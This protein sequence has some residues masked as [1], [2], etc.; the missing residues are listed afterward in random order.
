MERPGSGYSVGTG[1]ATTGGA[2]SGCTINIQSVGSTTYS[3]LNG[4]QFTAYS[5]SGTYAT[6]TLPATIRGVLI[7]DIDL[8]SSAQV[9][10]PTSQVGL[11]VAV[12]TQGSSSNIAINVGGGASALTGVT[13][14]AVQIGSQTAASGTNSGI[15]VLGSTGTGATN[16]GIVV[17]AAAGTN[18]TNRG[19]EIV[20][21][22]GSGSSVNI[23][24]MI[25]Q[26]SGGTGLQQA[27][28]LNTLATTASA[29]ILF[30]D[31]S[32]SPSANL[33]R[34]AASQV[35]CDGDIRARHFLGLGSTPSI[36]AG[37]GA[38]TGPSVTLVGTD[39]SFTV[40][41]TTGSAPSTSAVAFTVTF[42]TTYSQS[43]YPTFSA[44]SQTAGA[45]SGAYVNAAT[46]TTSSFEF[47]VGTTGL[48]ATTGYQWYFRV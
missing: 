12:Q 19:I 46:I 1:R 33:Y 13:N 28:W 23:G 15:V 7:N 30:G 10:R 27:L 17:T 16:R 29:G 9:A 42:A 47:K 3:T 34:G 6:P 41:L 22:T 31:N 18:A 20:G 45:F 44:A 37:A 36:A 48:S 14:T 2:G 8:G 11:N 40:S 39:T 25:S 24:L 21:P 32:D 5:A 38:G 43:V 4:A 35:K 26:P